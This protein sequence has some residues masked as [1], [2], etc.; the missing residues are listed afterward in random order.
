MEYR[1]INEEVLY[2]KERFVSL[3][4][5]EIDF[6]KKE[7]LKNPRQRIRICTHQSI[8]DNVHE[9]FI[10][11]AR[12]AYVR[13]HKHVNKAESLYLLEGEVDVIF[14]N[15]QGEKIKKVEMGP[16]HTGKTF[17]YRLSEPLYHTLCIKTDVIVFYEVTEGP[18]NRGDTVF[19][20]WAPDGSDAL[21]S[22]N[23]IRGL[24]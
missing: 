17:Y 5:G 20:T 24:A 10:V 19:P 4:A 13:P 7:A 8:E 11:H 6:L 15:D 2:P 14:F 18:F 21:L 9:M 23:F 12:D 22:Q 1:R 16:M 3:N